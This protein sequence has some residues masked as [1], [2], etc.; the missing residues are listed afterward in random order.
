MTASGGHQFNQ[1][2]D[3]AGA[4]AKVDQAGA[5]DSSASCA[6][7]DRRLRARLDRAGGVLLALFGMTG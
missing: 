6:G 7:L 2:L 5:T 1:K 4:R 3:R